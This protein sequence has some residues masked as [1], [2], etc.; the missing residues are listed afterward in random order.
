MPFPELDDGSYRSKSTMLLE[1][2][3]RASLADSSPW[4]RLV[5][6]RTQL[7]LTLTRF[8]HIDVRCHCTPGLPHQPPSSSVATVPVLIRLSGHRAQHACRE[9]TLHD[10][11]TERATSEDA[12]PST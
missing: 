4:P 12:V 5:S 7:P 2:L 10:N 1:A 11:C 3:I 8:L 9:E 6:C